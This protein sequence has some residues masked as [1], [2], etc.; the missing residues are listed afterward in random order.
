MSVP[1]ENSVI[2]WREML[3]THASW[4]RT[5]VYSRLGTPHE[6]DDVMQ[7]IALALIEKPPE[8]VE[9]QKVAPYLY[10]M[11]V[12]QSLLWRRKSGRRRK[13]IDRYAGLCEADSPRDYDPLEMLL[14]D[15]RRVLIRQALSSLNHRDAEILLMKYTMK[16]S[17]REI[18]SLLGVSESAVETRLHRARKRMRT[19]LAALEVVE[20]VE[21]H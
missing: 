13:K 21:V 8:N 11:A 4:L 5:V 3:M 12:R 10:R 19:A 18:A 16:S 6:V 17:Y 7:E 1:E 15:E 9:P 14:A 20:S 2:D